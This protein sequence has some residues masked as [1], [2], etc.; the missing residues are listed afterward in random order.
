VT[1]GY[2]DP[3]LKLHHV[4][5]AVQSIEAGLRPYTHAMG[6]S[7][8]SKI[9]EIA[10]QKVRVCFIETAPGIFVE[11]VQGLGEDSPVGSFLKRRQYY[12]HV[13]Y[14]TPD[15]RETVTNLES[16]GFQRLSVFTSEAFNGSDCAFLL[17][18]EMA[19]VEL[20]TD[21]KFSLL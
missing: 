20:C 1:A 4:G 3:S 6:F 14:S 18:P 12:Y 13:C 10:S 8:V 11:L 2:G 5:C 17:T 15:V 7:R 19:L 16:S 9:V 21:G